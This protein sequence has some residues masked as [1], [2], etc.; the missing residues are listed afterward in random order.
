MSETVPGVGEL[1]WR[2]VQKYGERR[3]KILWDLLAERLPEQSISHFG[4]PVWEDHVKFVY[5][6]G[7][8]SYRSWN[9]IEK[10][11]RGKWIPVGSIYLTHHNEIGVAIFKAWQRKGIAEWAVKHMVKWWGPSLKKS[12]YTGLGREFL[13][14]I[15][16]ENAP[17]IAFFEKLG[18]KMKQVTLTIAA[19]REFPPSKGSPWRARGTGGG[20]GQGRRPKIRLE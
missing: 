11:V 2:G 13:A 20:A 4:M 5:L 6:Y 12:K 19:P 1:R 7:R 18:F 16:P 9:I 8:K 10:Q 14:N 3:N 15:N 17:S